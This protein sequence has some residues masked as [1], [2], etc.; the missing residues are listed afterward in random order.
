MF[1]LIIGTVI[2]FLIFIPIVMGWPY[3]YYT[4]RDR[5]MERLAQPAPAAPP[6]QPPQ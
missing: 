2:F 5:E 1:G 3:L 4:K 6:Q